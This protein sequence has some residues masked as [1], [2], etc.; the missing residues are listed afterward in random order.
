MGYRTLTADEL[1]ALKAYAARKGR[2]WKDQLNTDWYYARLTG[3]LHSL[4]N[5]HGPRWLADFK[6]PKETARG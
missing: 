1:A 2:T 6:L 3:L 4:R 5:T